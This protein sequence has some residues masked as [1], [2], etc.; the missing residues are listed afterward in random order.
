MPTLQ[1]GPA[2]T[3]VCDPEAA[4]NQ[5]CC[6]GLRAWPEYWPLGVRRGPAGK[7]PETA[8]ALWVERRAHAAVESAVME[9]LRFRGNGVTSLSGPQRLPHS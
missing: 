6:S 4:P 8:S 7:E 3:G 5:R 9:L 1:S 2:T